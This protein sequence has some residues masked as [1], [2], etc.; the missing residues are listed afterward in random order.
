VRLVK[1]FI[2]EFRSIHDQWLPAEGL[3][4]LLGPNSAGKTSVLE[5]A[6]E[7][8]RGSGT[9]HRADPGEAEPAYAVGTLWFDLPAADDRGSKDAAAYRSLL[10][11]E[12][13]EGWAGEGPAWDWL[14]PGTAELLKGASAGDARA[15][16]AQLLAGSGMAGDAGDRELL[17]R[18]V[19]EASP[20]FA[21]DAEG[22]RLL[23]RAASLPGAAIDAAA[24]IAAS[25]GSGDRLQEIAA[26]LGTRA[27][28]DVATVA[29]GLFSSRILAAALPPVIVLDGYPGS[30]SAELTRAIPVIHDLLWSIADAE[31]STPGVT[32][33]LD[34]FVLEPG[35]DAGASYSVDP[36][37]EGLSDTGETV[38]PR[39]IPDYSTG[40]WYRVRHSVVATAQMIAAEAN[41]RAPSFVKDQGIIGVE[42]VPVGAWDSGPHRVRAT[43]TGPDRQRRDLSVTGSGTARSGRPARRRR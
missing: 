34:P 17:A 22:I 12:D 30:L 21:A 7:L 41:R 8:V 26:Q 20:L 39:K 18:A 35:P 6:S 42:V 14:E 36:W 3:V 1:I 24:H 23:V 29:V 11:G 31:F 19:F 40:D 9:K 10:C 16:L 2:E 32:W 37:L 33:W 28:A 13:S 38:I 25:P 15:H 27:L 43:F 5:A 4:V